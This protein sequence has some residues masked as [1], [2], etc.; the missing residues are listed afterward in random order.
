[1][2]NPLALPNGPEI[3]PLARRGHKMI[4]NVSTG[5]SA[6]RLTW[7]AV[8]QVYAADL[9][10]HFAAAQALGLEC[11]LDIF[12]QL[13][14]DHHD[15]PELARV[16]RFVDCEAVRKLPAHLLQRAQPVAVGDEHQ[17][18]VPSTTRPAL[19]CGGQHL[20]DLLGGPDTHGAGGRRWTVYEGGGE[21]PG[22]PCTSP[23]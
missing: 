19:A 11:P 18:A 10:E 9:T 23:L 17:R 20:V 15:D 13:F 2:H 1:V 8:Q 5:T 3:Q 21:K 22:P 7:N 16:L 6:S 12:E 14:H 4:T